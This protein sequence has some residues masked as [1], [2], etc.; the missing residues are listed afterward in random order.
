MPNIFI[1][2]LIFFFHVSSTL[3]S[4]NMKLNYITLSENNL[5]ESRILIDRKKNKIENKGKEKK[6]E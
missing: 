1:I 4:E 3:K 6:K 5:P 2:F